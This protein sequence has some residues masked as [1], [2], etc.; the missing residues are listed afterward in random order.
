M[1]GALSAESV[2][3][4]NTQGTLNSVVWEEKL[5]LCNESGTLVNP[6]GEF[7]DELLLQRPD[8]IQHIPEN[9]TEYLPLHEVVYVT[10]GC[11]N[12]TSAWKRVTAVTRH[13]P[14]GDLV[15]IKTRSGRSVTMTH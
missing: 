6:I 14:V 8:S 3:E 2:G 1:V 15:K 5:L 7:I 10:T 9:H 4:G 13:L 11:N 12:G